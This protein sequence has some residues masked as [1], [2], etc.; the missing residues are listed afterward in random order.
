MSGGYGGVSH[1]TPPG[2]KMIATDFALRESSVRPSKVLSI[3][4]AIAFAIGIALSL[5]V[6]FFLNI[7]E[8]GARGAALMT[9][10]WN[11]LFIMILPLVLDWSERRHCK[12]R[13]LELEEIANANP[14]LADAISEQCLKMQIPKLRLAVASQPSDELFSYGLWGYN[15]RLILPDNLLESRERTVIIPSIEAELTRFASQDNT[16]VFLLFTIIQI[17]FQQIVVTVF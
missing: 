17:V 11:V 4:Y 12:V 14:E 16:I 5:P 2:R 6:A 13:F 7:D 10:S 3:Y 9:L 15:P 1:S 8:V